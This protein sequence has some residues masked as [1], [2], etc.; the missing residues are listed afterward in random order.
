MSRPYPSA[1][2][3]IP[4]PVEPSV[5]AAKKPTPAK[6]A[7][8]PAKAGPAPKAKAA[9]ASK[10]PSG[11]RADVLAAAERGVIPS[12]PDFSAATHTRF[13]GKLAEVVALVE[14][15]NIAGLKAYKINPV[16]S[17]PK[18][19]D[20]YRNLAIIA[21]KAKAPAPNRS[22]VAPFVA[23]APICQNDCA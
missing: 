1:N 4:P 21:L 20:K 15:G 8:K 11:K 17:S 3:F 7:S 5:E 23:P 13:R 12:A 10:G 14:A 6:T 16:S 9:P 19:I 22:L 18:A 2:G